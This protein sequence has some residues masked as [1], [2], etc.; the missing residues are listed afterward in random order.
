MAPA[1]IEVLLS[2]NNAK[3]VLKSD[4]QRSAQ[5]FPQFVSKLTAAHPITEFFPLYY[6]N[7]L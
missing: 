1:G 5:K 3:S 2:I 4:L 7:F 6:L